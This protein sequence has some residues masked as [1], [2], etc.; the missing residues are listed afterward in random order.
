M[1]EEKKTSS[2]AQPEEKKGPLRPTV[3]S[4]EPAV[5]QPVNGDRLAARKPTAMTSSSVERLQGPQ[6]IRRPT[7]MVGEVLQQIAITL[8]D[9][10][11]QNTAV[12]HSV[13]QDALQQI[14]SCN[15]DTLNDR[16][17]V[18]WGNEVQQAYSELVTSVLDLS[19]SE[20]L[21][22]ASRRVKRLEDLL[23]S[24]RLDSIY[25]NNGGFFTSIFKKGNQLIETPAALK[26]ALREINE[27]VHLLGKSIDQLLDLKTKF[28]LASS[29]AEQIRDKAEARS[30]AALAVAN[31]LS[32][33]QKSLA[34]SFIGRAMALTATCAQIERDGSVRK[35]QIE[36]PLKL[37]TVVQNVVLITLPGLIGT[38]A[39]LQ[40]LMS[41]NNKPTVTHFQEVGDQIAT[42]LKGLKV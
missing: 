4:L 29:D 28:E 42:T 10:R 22:I 18:L 15:P 3:M 16:V 20:V 6:T 40:T 1:P 39:S 26:E 13:L 19:Q 33:N 38:I 34:D 2:G 35:L 21:V 14:K 9:L 8:V 11:T 24:I 31:Y 5:S 23:G 41:E 17:A 7:A 27:L 30:I 12:K 36:Q 37:I 32:G 25:K